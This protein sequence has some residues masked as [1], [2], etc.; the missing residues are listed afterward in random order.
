MSA[1]I[2]VG[3]EIKDGFKETYKWVSNNVKWLSEIE[4][5]Y[6]ER[7]KL[8][9]EYSVKLSNLT[10]EYF[11]KKSSA[12]VSLSV[13]DSPTI[14]P[15]SL[16]AASLVAWNE[17]LSQTEMI[18]K[19][20]NKL[21]QEFEFEIADQIVA[22]NRKCELLLT[23]ISGFNTELTE[24]KE[25]AFD[26]LD[27]AK[28]HY[29]EACTQMESA[30]AKQTKSSSDKAQ[31]RV[32]DK[33]HN[34]NITKNNY[35]IKINQANRLKDKYYFQDVP[36]ALDL[37]QD[38]NESKTRLLNNLL[39]AAGVLE[40]QLHKRVDT[41]LDTIDSV[42]AQNKPHLDSSMFIKHNI[43][44]WKEPADFKYIPSPV[45]HDDEQFVVAS[46]V[47][48]QDLKVKL[49]KAQQLFDQM[50][51]ITQNEGSSLG[52]LNKQKQQLKDDETADGKQ[53]LEILTRYSSTVSAFTSHETSKLEAEVEIES[54]QNN[55]PSEYDLSTD[56][57]DLSKLEK[58][59]GFLSKFKRNMTISETRP[60]HHEI[61]DSASILSSESKHHSLGRFSIFKKRDRAQSTASAS[62]LS[63]TTSNDAFPDTTADQ[64]GNR[65]LY[66]YKMQDSD[67]VDVSPGDTITL[68]ARD[69]GNGWT[70]IKNETTDKVGMVP[71]SYIE[72]KEKPRSPAPRAPPPRKATV[73]TRT[74]EALYDYT[75]QGDDEISI[76]EGSIITVIKEDDGSGWTFGE[77]NGHK[78]LFPTSYCK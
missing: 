27:K 62:A 61:H 24:R 18:S 19:D 5:F 38:L 35:L 17:V 21:S 22:L 6:K 23:S 25:Q 53:L 49:V 60:T 67:E 50:S 69:S 41:R 43:K 37:L 39:K 8:E 73:T 11:T 45:W 56:D 46:G 26:N 36:E 64:T 65:V 76:S 13:G 20:H 10:A 28:K 15:G 70:Q 52:S 42:V 74:V 44:S 1:D 47:E 32:D 29:D 75:A 14:T 77:V 72:I 51:S 2:S 12:T 71:S 68:V 58:K 9:K 3:N 40:R 34:M 31:R 54:I 48:L 63:S 55:V 33:E 57:I 7:A 78:G 4:A 16:E 66:A 30:R 59:G